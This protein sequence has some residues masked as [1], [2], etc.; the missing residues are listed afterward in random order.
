MIHPYKLI[1]GTAPKDNASLK[2][3]LKKYP[4]YANVIRSVAGNIKHNSLRSAELTIFIGKNKIQL[5]FIGQKGT[6]TIRLSIN[7][8]TISEK[9]NGLPYISNWNGYF[10]RCPHLKKKLYV[11][12][13]H[14]VKK[15]APIGVIFVNKNEQFVLSAPD[16]GHIYFPSADR[17]PEQ[18][19]L[20]EKNKTV[21]FHLDA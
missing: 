9:M 16:S 14:S 7:D 3:I 13:G 11:K 20:L 12:N 5:S 10:Y 21:L 19:L 6:G 18:G 15:G 17:N 4:L 8:E 2:D 1:S